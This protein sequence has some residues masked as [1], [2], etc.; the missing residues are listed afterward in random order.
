MAGFLIGP[1]GIAAAAVASPVALDAT[2]TKAKSTT[3]L[4]TYDF[5]GMTVGTGNALIVTVTYGDVNVTG[6]TASWDNG[7]TPQSMTLLASQDQV[8]NVGTTAIFGLR[9]PTAGNKTLRLNWTGSAQVF[10]DAISFTGVNVTS[11]ATAFPVAGRT[12]SVIGPTTSPSLDVT[13]ATNHMTVCATTNQGNNY[14][15]ATQ[16]SM[17]IDNTGASINCAA[18]YASGAATVSF[19]WTSSASEKSAMV[20]VDVSN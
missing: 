9:S 12:A 11:D 2:G 17:F 4:T 16:T 13:S 1:S 19:G 18:A 8:F 14:S 3:G 7:G 15:A 10:V 20:G 6:M 5:T